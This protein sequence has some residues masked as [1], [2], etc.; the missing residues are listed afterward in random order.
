MAAFLPAIGVSIVHV[1]G[2][3]TA[4]VRVGEIT[5]AQLVRMLADIASFDL[6]DPHV[7]ATAI[8]RS[9]RPAMIHALRRVIQG[10]SETQQN[11]RTCLVFVG[12][13]NAPITATMLG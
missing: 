2:N 12:S 1:S 11:E 7:W 9:H 3:E 13:V 8:Y 6:E 5:E 4:T 10:W